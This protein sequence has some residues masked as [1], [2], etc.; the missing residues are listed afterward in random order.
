VYQNVVERK[1]QWGT[2]P[3]KAAGGSVLLNS[4]ESD[5]KMEEGALPTGIKVE[6]ET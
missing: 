4:P 3:S 2:L 1:V 6:G 5:G